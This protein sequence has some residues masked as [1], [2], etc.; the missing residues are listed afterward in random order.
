MIAREV[1]A[2]EPCTVV[3]MAQQLLVEASMLL[4]QRNDRRQLQ[5]IDGNLF[6]VIAAVEYAACTRR[7]CA[8]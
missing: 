8:R 6:V 4:S 2:F 3:R 1:R 7:D 5:S